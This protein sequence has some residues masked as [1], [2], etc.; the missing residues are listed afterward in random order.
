MKYI[1]AKPLG[2]STILLCR[3]F[4]NYFLFAVNCFVLMNP[5][6]YLSFLPSVFLDAQYKKK[7]VMPQ[8]IVDS[9][10]FEQFQRPFF[11]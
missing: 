6:C 10:F 5:N 7:K 8:T 11:R 4:N 9:S 1:H 3:I 2:S